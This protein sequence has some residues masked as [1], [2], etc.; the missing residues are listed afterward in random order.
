M[1]YV[2]RWVR[3]LE[4]GLELCDSEYCYDLIV[5]SLVDLLRN[6]DYS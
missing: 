3:S 4:V 1:I 5:L 2:V 6:N